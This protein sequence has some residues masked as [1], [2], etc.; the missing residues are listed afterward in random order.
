MDLEAAL[1]YPELAR[2]LEAV[3]LERRAGRTQAPERLVMAL[4]EGGTL[5]LMPASDPEIAVTK[6]VTVHPRQRPSVRAE[7]VVMDACT[8]ERLAQLDGSVVTARRTAALSLLAAQKLAP[9]PP[10]PE[11]VLLVVGA[12]VQGRSHL[13]AF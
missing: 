8:G 7:L 3:L 4:P 12:G 2:A 11:D 5:L 9:R 10:E 1:P 6:L 13:E